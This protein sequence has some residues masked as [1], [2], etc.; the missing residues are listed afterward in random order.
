MSQFLKYF[1]RAKAAVR[2]PGIDFKTGL[3]PCVFVTANAGISALMIYNHT[4]GVDTYV[5]KVWR[6][7]Q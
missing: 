3:L 5:D 4:Y 2:I 6:R 1:Q 7:H